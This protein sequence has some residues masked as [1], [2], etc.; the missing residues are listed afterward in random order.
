MNKDLQLKVNNANHNWRV[1]ILLGGN[2]IENFPSEGNLNEF[3]QKG[4]MQCGAAKV[5]FYRWDFPTV[6]SFTPS[7]VRKNLKLSGLPPAC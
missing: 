1:R 6:C 4:E 2:F 7:S 3:I 5:M